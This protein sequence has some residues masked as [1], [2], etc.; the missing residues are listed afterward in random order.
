VVYFKDGLLGRIGRRRFPLGALRPTGGKCKQGQGTGS[1]RPTHHQWAEAR[2]C[3]KC[4]LHPA[5]SASHGG[6]ALI[7][8]NPDGS[9]W[10]RSPHGRRDVGPG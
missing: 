5:Y 10:S 4:W 3:F 9:G 6:V 1:H 8:A 7:V 2:G